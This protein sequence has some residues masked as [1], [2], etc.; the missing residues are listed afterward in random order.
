M[1]VD[2][3]GDA[4]NVRSE[5]EVGNNFTVRGAYVTNNHD[6]CFQNDGMKSGT[7]EE[8]LFDGCYVSFS[9]RGYGSGTTNTVTIRNNLV[10]LQAFPTY[11]GGSTTDPSQYR[12]GGFWKIDPGPGPAWLHGHHRRVR[13]GQ[14]VDHLE[15]EPR[16]ALTGRHRT[17]RESGAVQVTR[18]QQRRR[19]ESAAASTSRESRDRRG[20]ACRSFRS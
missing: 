4:I 17:R 12:N 13:V 15:G 20:T 10:R 5:V 8:S 18:G 11:Y 2:N 6:D 3:Y 7:I 1:R 14:R 19:P 16:R 9:T